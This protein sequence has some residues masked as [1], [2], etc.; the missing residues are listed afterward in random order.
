MTR[1]GLLPT[2]RKA[3]DDPLIANDPVWRVSA[4]QLRAGHGLPLGLNANVLLDAMREPLRGVIDSELTPIEATE[5]MQIN[6]ER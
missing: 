1:F 4:L 5:L 2:R 6:L 3:L